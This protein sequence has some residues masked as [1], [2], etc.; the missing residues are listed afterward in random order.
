MKRKSRINILEKEIKELKKEIKILKG[1]LIETL[2]GP[3]A[4]LVKDLT[5]LKR[6]IFIKRVYK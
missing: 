3:I 5:S 2:E 1:T 4:D 6:E